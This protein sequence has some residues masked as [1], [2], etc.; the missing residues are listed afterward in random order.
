MFSTVYIPNNSQLYINEMARVF[1]QKSIEIASLWATSG[2]C[3]VYEAAQDMFGSI[4]FSQS[5]HSRRA[6]WLYVVPAFG[7]AVL[8]ANQADAIA[9]R[10]ADSVCRAF[11][12]CAK[13]GRH[14]R[15]SQRHLPV[16]TSPI[17]NGPAMDSWRSRLTCNRGTQHML[18]PAR[19]YGLRFR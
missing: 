5:L 3:Y 18:R 1:H 4:M 19:R 13:P 15:V 7:L 16:G 2:S 17:T 6:L 14:Y 11:S 12:L 10:R 9:T 8:L